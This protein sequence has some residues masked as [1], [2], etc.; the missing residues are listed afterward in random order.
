VI[1]TLGAEGAYCLE[2]A[3]I[4]YLIPA[5]PAE[6]VVDTIGAG[7][8]N[9]GTVL[10]CL[11]KGWFLRN[12]IAYAN[13]VSSAVIGVKGATLSAHELPSIVEGEG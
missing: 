5:V 8:A 10:A 2:K 13:K 3:G 7:D 12:A 11:T 9:I 6:C 4:D 1:I